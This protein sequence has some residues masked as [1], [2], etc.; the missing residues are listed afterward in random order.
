MEECMTIERDYVI[1]ASIGTVFAAL[2]E[3]QAILRWWGS[4]DVYW[5][6]N[7]E[8]ELRAGAPVLYAGR[9][10]DGKTFAGTGVTQSVEAPRML[11]Y[12]RLYFNGIPIV[13]ET[14]IRYDLDERNGCTHVR[15]MHAGFHGAEA[16]NQHGNGWD[17]AFVWLSK[18]LTS[19]NGESQEA[20]S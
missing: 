3:P 15:V 10:A 18:Y 9:F 11:E 1:E 13:E 19:Q 4:D 5:M 14:V 20:K 17:R 2:T 6:T 16:A 8:H 7:V 12:T